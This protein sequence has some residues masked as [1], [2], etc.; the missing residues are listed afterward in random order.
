[1]ELIWG[2]QVT[3]GRFWESVL[4]AYSLSC[5]PLTVHHVMNS[6]HHMFLQPRRE[7]PFHAFL[8]TVDRN[9]LK[10]AQTNLSSLKSFLPCV[11]VRATQ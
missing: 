11:T 10:Q 7:L 6:L 1:M 2:E 9:L 8:I 3:G 5:S 4:P